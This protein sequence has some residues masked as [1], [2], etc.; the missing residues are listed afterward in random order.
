MVL[1]TTRRTKERFER[2][3]GFPKIMEYSAFENV[4]RIEGKL[5][6]SSKT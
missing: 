3:L 6:I 1:L 4:T 2:A 5:G